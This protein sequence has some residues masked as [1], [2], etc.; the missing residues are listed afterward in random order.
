[1]ATYNIYADEDNVV[2]G[3]SAVLCATQRAASSGNVL[4]TIG[5]WSVYN[6]TISGRG[7]T[8]TNIGRYFLEFDSSSVSGSILSAT[9]KVH[10]RSGSGTTLDWIGIKSTQSNPLV[11]GDFDALD[12]CSGALLHS[13]GSG[14]GTLYGNATEYTNEITTWDASDYNDIVLNPIAITA[15]EAG[16]IKICLIGY[17]NDY[18]DIASLGLNVSAGVTTSNQTG[19]SSDPYLVIVTEDD[20]ANA[21][22]FGANT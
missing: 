10:G 2:Y 3:Y 7:G 13:D 21:M 9:L 6:M 15:L 5:T 20:V 14:N 1:M 12:G 11:T 16:S 4:P 8:V 17:D 19:T 18:L 22:A